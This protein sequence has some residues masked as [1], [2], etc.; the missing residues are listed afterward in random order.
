MAT[1][2]KQAMAVEQDEAEWVS[3]R[4]AAKLLGTYREAVLQIA[5]KGQLT[6]EHRGKWT[7]VSR[8]SLER[9]VA[10]NGGALGK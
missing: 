7:F 5:L 6:V 9:Y 8:E 10:R 2:R 3:L 4:T 1:V